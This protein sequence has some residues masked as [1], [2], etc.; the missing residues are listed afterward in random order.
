MKI[1]ALEIPISNKEKRFINDGLERILSSGVK[2]TNSDTVKALETT[3]AQKTGSEYAIAVSTGSVA[4][5]SVLIAKGLDNAIIFAPVLTAPP[6]VLSCLNMKSNIVLVDADANDF[7][8][9]PADLEQKIKRHRKCGEKAVIIYVHI[10][11]FIS[12]NIKR[13]KAIADKHD[14]VLIED[15]AH[16][17]G[18]RLD[19]VHAGNFGIAGIFSFFLTKTITSG[20]GGIVI[21]KDKELADKLSMIRNYGKDKGGLHVVKGSSWRLNEFSALVLLSQIRNC[22]TKYARRQEIAV[23]YNEAFACHD[24]FQPIVNLNSGYYKYI[25]RVRE[26]V[27][28]DYQNFKSYMQQHSIQLPAKVYDSLINEEP[29]LKSCTD[30]IINLDSSFEQ[31]GF[32]KS[33]H[34]CLPMHLGLSNDDVKYVIE[35]IM[36]YR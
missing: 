11:G 30:Q 3:F 23:T 5:E 33:H 21:A 6:T 15:C 1:N 13:I 17:H 35:T 22:E 36:K 29:Y 14:V 10:G 9:D 7:G 24:L 34:V 2:W 27:G 32:L 12:E 8:M 4:I 16:A 31:A 20:E 19:N 18:A 26:N 25:L 28:F